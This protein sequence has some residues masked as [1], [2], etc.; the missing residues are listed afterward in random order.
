[1]KSVFL[2][3]ILSLVS[4]AGVGTLQAETVYAATE[5]RPECCYKNG[6]WYVGG[7]NEL[8]WERRYPGAWARFELGS[9]PYVKP[10]F[11][12]ISEQSDIAGFEKGIY[13]TRK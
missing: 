7:Q 6:Q 10:N 9:S 5:N 3:L 8:W 2:I 12:D 1:M 4:L 13:N 11:A